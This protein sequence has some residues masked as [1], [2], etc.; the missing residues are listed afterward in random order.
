MLMITLYIMGYIAFATGVQANAIEEEERVHKATILEKVT[1]RSKIAIQIVV[2]LIT[3]YGVVTSVNPI[4]MKMLDVFN[5]QNNKGVVGLF[6]KVRSTPVYPFRISIMDGCY[7]LSAMG[8]IVAYRAGKCSH[9]TF[10]NVKLDGV[11]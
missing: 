10:D 11:V 6:S 5:I 7:I 1:N 8:A 2:G 9:V 3:L 4:K